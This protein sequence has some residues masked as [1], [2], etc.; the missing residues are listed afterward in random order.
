MT[1]AGRDHPA[2]ATDQQLRIRGIRARGLDL[3]LA[4]PVE[5]AAG[6]MRTAPLVLIDLATEEGVTGRGYVRCYTP[7]ALAPL[8]RLVANLEELVAGDAAEPAAVEAKLQRHFRLLGPQGLV[9]MAIAGIDM[10]LWDACARAAGVPLARFLGGTP[11]PV[12]AYASLRTMRPDGAAAEAAE[13]VAG[14][15]RAIKVKV[16][17]G[18]LAADLDTIGAVRGAVGD[19][20]EL[21]VDYNQSL[22]VGEAIARAR[23][24]DHE[25]L[26]WIE[27]PTRADDFE[28]HA[29]VA[30]AAATPIQLGENWWGPHDMEKS[31]AAHASDQV[32]LDVMKLGGVTGWR[33]GAALAD[34]AGLPASSHTF[35]ELSVHLLAVTP[36]RR[37]LEYLDHAGPILTEPI[38]VQ[39]GQA[40]PP[41]RPGSGLEWDEELIGR[42]PASVLG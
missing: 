17:R 13:L 21:M 30:A 9:G 32:T 6:V 11:A 26:S 29:R 28:G 19:G 23:A 5:T 41:D 1:A 31:I 12:P 24:L 14:G 20:V 38:R 10:A 2:I 36:T 34:A 15:F 39:D 4:R 33:R 3:A 35:P 8:T 22:S 42:L 27:E 16:G 18:D 25:G 40:L 7:L 37:W